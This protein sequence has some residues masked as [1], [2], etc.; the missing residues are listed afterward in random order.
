MN[1]DKATRHRKVKDLFVNAL[2]LPANKRRTWLEENTGDDESLCAE[3]LDLLDAHDEAESE[4][5]FNSPITLAREENA[6]RSANVGQVL[7]AWRLEEFLGRGGMGSVFK[8]VRADGAFEKEAAVKVVRSDINV[9]RVAMRF[10]QERHTLAKLDHRNV[11]RLIDGGTSDVGP[12]LVME[13]IVGLPITQFCQ[14]EELSVRETVELFLQVC[15]AV[16]YAHRNLVVHRDLKPSNILVANDGTVKL[17]DFGIA[18]LLDSEMEAVKVLTSS[19]MTPAYAAPEQ[20]VNAPVTTATDTYSLGVLLFELLSG[21]RPYELAG[22]TPS[23]IEATICTETPPAPSRLAQR[24]GLRSVSADL[25]M[26]VLKALEKETERRYTTAESLGDDLRRFLAGDPVTARS[27]TAAYRFSKFIRKNKIA[28]AASTTVLLSMAGGLSF[29]LWQA[30]VASRER[31]RAEERFDLA[32][33]VT[34]TLLFDIHDAVSNL[35]GSTPAREMI[36]ARSLSYLEELDK[37]TTGQTQL[38]IDIANAYRRI[39]DVLGNPS[40][41]NLGRVTDAVQSYEKGL[42]ALSGTSDTDSL[43]SEVSRTRA[44]LFEKLADVT[45]HTGDIEAALRHLDHSTSNFESAL[46]ESPDVNSLLAVAIGKIKQGDYTGNRHFPNLEEPQRANELY[47]ESLSLIMKADSLEP[48]NKRVQRYQGLIHERFGTVQEQLGQIDASRESYRLSLS[49]RE[50]LWRNN[51]GDMTLYRDAGIAHE[52]VGLNY[53]D[54]GNLDM[55]L[56]ELKTAYSY[57]NDIVERD[58]TNAN[59]R[60]T[61]AVSEMQLGALMFSSSE[62]HFDDV[63]AS[64]QHYRHARTILDDVHSIDTSNV[65]TKSLLEETNRVLSRLD[66]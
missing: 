30:E 29:A 25:D 49:F 10:E 14:D 12:F 33:E 13:Y 17:L 34:S 47:E 38:R 46:G 52:K 53:Q 24:S 6:T 55:A 15:D 65:R 8:A 26:I 22:K 4:G 48:E 19:A 7:G 64:L 40:N 61:L 5:S 31:D 54:D 20:I 32:R 18:K 57:F 42:S 41:D 43:A 58:P 3:V 62:P 66:K 36:I 16:G 23:Q 37:T 11:A 2:D 1:E 45:A 63:P 39:G 44:M 28:V 27:P 50:K 59:A 60:I 51:P 9:D 56:N 35:S 21:E